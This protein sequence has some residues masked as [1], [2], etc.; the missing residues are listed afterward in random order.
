VRRAS[1]ATAILLL[2]A[3]VNSCT[4]T[5]PSAW[6]ASPYSLLAGDYTLVVYV[7]KGDAG[8]YVICVAENDV[9]DTVSVPV[10]VTA[11]TGG[12]R[13]TPATD[14]DLGLVALLQMADPTTI[15]GP[16]LGQARDP[17]TGVVVTIT[18]SIDPYSPTQSDAT[19]E[20]TMS[21]RA[22]AAGSVSGSVQF[23]LGGKARWCT[24]NRWILHPR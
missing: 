7:P 17:G 23:S 4:P 2:A 22:F 20:G 1:G 13:V 15:Y 12:W 3:A 10:T 11:I 8:K 18:P 14:A 19:L 9:P 24:P 5:S 21:S 6:A 16:I